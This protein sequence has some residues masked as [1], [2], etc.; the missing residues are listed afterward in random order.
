MKAPSDPECEQQKEERKEVKQAHRGETDRQT[1]VSPGMG[2]PFFQ[3]SSGSARSEVR[4]ATGLK[5]RTGE[6]SVSH[7]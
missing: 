4:A 7:Q 2:A 3:V 5:V 6:P 1:H